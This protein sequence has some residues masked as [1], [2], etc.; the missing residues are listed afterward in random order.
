MKGSRVT[1]LGGRKTT[2]KGEDATFLPGPRCARWMGC[3]IEG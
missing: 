1:N 2:D 3:G